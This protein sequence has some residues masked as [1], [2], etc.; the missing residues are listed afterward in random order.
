MASIATLEFPFSFGVS[1]DTTHSEKLDMDFNNDKYLLLD[2][3]VPIPDDQV[4]NLTKAICLL[5]KTS[6]FRVLELTLIRYEDERSEPKKQTFA[7]GDYDTRPL[8]YRLA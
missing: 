3:K 1:M 5:G 2:F 6:E 8:F 4:D 7:R